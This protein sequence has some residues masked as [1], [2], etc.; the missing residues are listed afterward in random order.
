[1]CDVLAIVAHNDD[2]IVGAG[3]TLARYAKE[4]LSFKTI[5]FSF[6]E[7]SHPHFR[8][9]VIQKQ[10]ILESQQSDKLLGGSGVVYIGLEEGNFVSQISEKKIK[11][12]ILDIIAK[13]KPKVIFTHSRNDFHPDHRAVFDFV[14]VLKPFI[15]AKIYAFGVWSLLPSRVPRMVVDVSKTF[16]LKIRA[17][18]IHES[19]STA[20]A[21]L[22]WSIYLNNFFAGRQIGCRFAEVF[23]VVK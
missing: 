7:K 9:R 19:Q 10:R 5:V 18:R 11:Q 1:M 13:E 20:I 14:N 15:D 16:D 6:G 21:T 3:G 2:Q 23:E 17:F 8:P 4:G 12:K 22:L